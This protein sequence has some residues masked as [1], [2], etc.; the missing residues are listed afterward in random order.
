[1]YQADALLRREF[2]CCSVISGRDVDALVRLARAAL[3]SSSR[4]GSIPVR[5][6]FQRL[7]ATS[8]LREPWTSSK[9]A[10]PAS[11]LTV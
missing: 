6:A 1:V 2:P 4:S 10:C 9:S 8:V 5:V 7:Q 11:R 3:R